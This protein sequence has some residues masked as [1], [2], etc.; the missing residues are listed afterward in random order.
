MSGATVDRPVLNE[1]MRRVEEGESGGIVVYD[2]KRFGRTLIDSLGLIKRITE[3]GATFASV[4]DGFDLSTQGGRLA[5][6]MMLV[7]AEDE[8]ERITANWDEARRRA[9]ERG[10]HL[11][12]TVPFGYRRRD[13]NGL[14]PDPVN[15][16]VLTELFERRANGEGWSDL[17]RWMESIGA[18]T[19][20]GRATWS[21]RALRD[22]VRNDVYLGVAE[23]GQ[24]RREGAHEPLTDE[25]TWRRAQR[26]GSQTASRA[27]EP[28]L[29]GG[30]LRCAG[31]RHVMAA[32]TQ[33]L[34]DGRLLHYFRCRQA[35]GPG[36]CSCPAWASL[37]G[38]EALDLVEQLR[39]GLHERARVWAEAAEASSE[40]LAAANTARA[41]ATLAEYAADFGLQERIGW[42]A[43]QA[44][45]DARASAVAEAKA[46]EERER[47]QEEAEATLPEPEHLDEGAWSGYSVEERRLLVRSG[48]DT[49][50]VRRRASRDDP[51]AGRVH[52]RWHGM[53]PVDL[54]GKGRRDYAP[55]PFLFDG[56]GDIGAPAPQDREPG[57]TDRVN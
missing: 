22:I 4:Q 18:K 33:T 7:L 3:A 39:A 52:V 34:A 5:M 28:A 25:V 16:P 32:K 41:R 9:V 23:H 44:G 45:L 10:V 35:D 54:P 6:R 40:S 27:K 30:L 56:P 21:L 31:C 46:A 57:T 11:T 53:D 47:D 8:L 38:V 36:N 1:A 37:S 42:E 24:F 29:L 48:I 51:L 19:Q 17:S 43:Y 50:F 12:A 26:R 15:A 55:R 20:R 2:V 13:D 14:E 49:V